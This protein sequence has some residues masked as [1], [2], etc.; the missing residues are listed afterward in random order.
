ML[1][2]QSLR[3]HCWLCTL[4]KQGDNTNPSLV[5][6]A[7]T[8]H[9]VQDRTMQKGSLLAWILQYGSIQDLAFFFYS[10]QLWGGGGQLELQYI[11]TGHTVV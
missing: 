1:G 3:H 11:E 9:V 5:R 2:T 10:Y 6:H 4:N 8:Q 7:D